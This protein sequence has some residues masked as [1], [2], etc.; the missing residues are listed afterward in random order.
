MKELVLVVHVLAAVGLVALVLLQQ[1]KGADVGAAFGSGASQTLF[2]ARGSA[3]FLTRVTAVLATTFFVTSL[4]LAVLAT[5]TSAPPSVT[6]SVQ[7]EPAST[8]PAPETEAPLVPETP[9]PTEV[10]EV[11]R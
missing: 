1:G 11:P 4:T 7:T 2:G 9:V 8:Q 3:N 6:E 5:R 10:P